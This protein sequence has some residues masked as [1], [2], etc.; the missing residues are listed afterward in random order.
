MKKIIPTGFLMLLALS[1]CIAQNTPTSKKQLKAFRNHPHWVSMMDDSTVNYHEAKAAFDEFWKGK[2]T[3]EELNEGE[4]EEE[5]EE[6]ERNIF[7]RIL[8]SD[9]QYKAEIVQYAFEHRKFNYWLRTNAP[10]VRPDGSL[11]SQAERDAMVQQEIANRNTASAT[12]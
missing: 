12:K 6:H 4:F 7:A 3:P 2:P 10:Y 9:K 1:T 8:K 11:M 5:N